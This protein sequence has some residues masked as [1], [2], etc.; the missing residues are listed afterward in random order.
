MRQVCRIL[1]LA[2]LLTAPAAA[3]AGELVLRFPGLQPR[4]QLV[5]AVFASEAD[6]KARARP[7][8]Q[9]IR[10]VE[11]GPAEVR[12]DGLPAGAYAV[13]AYH[14]RNANGRLDTLPVGLPTEPYG[15]SADAR[16]AF[17][18]P[19]WSRAKLDLGV[20]PAVETLRLR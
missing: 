12:F 16:G 3:S 8:R 1:A 5:V 10:P 13:M 4:G 19:A 7:I 6:W 2:V 18:P 15:F 20:K 17:G 14:D 9:A 11:G